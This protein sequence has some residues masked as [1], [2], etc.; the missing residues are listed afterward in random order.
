MATIRATQASTG[1][2]VRPLVAPCG[3]PPVFAVLVWRPNH[4]RSPG[5]RGGKSTEEDMKTTTRICLLASAALLSLGLA[6][7]AQQANMTFFVTSVGS[8][9]G[10]NL[11]GL[12]GAD[13]HCQ[14]LAAAAGAGSHTWHAY[15]STDG[16]GAV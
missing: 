2:L 7:Q 10:A 3:I 16:A 12:T 13:K 6:A 14:D 4:V 11:G 8:G 15:L 9:N 1:S 5:L